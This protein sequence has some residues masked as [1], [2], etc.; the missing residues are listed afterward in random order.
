MDRGELIQARR[1]LAGLTQRELAAAAGVSLP[2]VERAERGCALTSRTLRKI[3]D[4]LRLSPGDRAI[5]VGW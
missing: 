2:T 5:L 3:A 1:Q 4:A